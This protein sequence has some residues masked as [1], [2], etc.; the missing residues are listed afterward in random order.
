MT[1]AQRLRCA[2]LDA[3]L[4]SL[5]RRIRMDRDQREVERRPATH[6]EIVRLAR[7][8]AVAEQLKIET[9]GTGRW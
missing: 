6:P 5:E 3:Q 1:R 8:D 7:K 4:R 2:I 9:Y